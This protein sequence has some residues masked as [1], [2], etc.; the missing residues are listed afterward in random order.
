M[1]TGKPR[2]CGVTLG[3]VAVLLL[4]N[5]LGGRGSEEEAVR[6]EV[7][8]TAEQT[9]KP[10]ENAIIYLK[11]KEEHFLRRDK[12]REWSSKT[13]A[14]GKAVFPPLPEGR[15]LVQVVAHGWKTYGRYHELRGPKHVLE[16][17]LSPPRKWY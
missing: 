17:K 10:I 14:E 7:E 3:W 2:L 6:L 8:V 11:F 13:N 5:P 4:L 16:I 12:K 9:G 15:A 1:I